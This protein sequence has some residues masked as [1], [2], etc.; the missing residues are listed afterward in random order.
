MDEQGE[1]D[2]LIEREDVSG[3]ADLDAIPEVADAVLV[4]APEHGEE[5]EA[6]KIRRSSRVPG[7]DAI[8]G[9]RWVRI[10]LSRHK[11]K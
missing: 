11:R 7:V 10:I 4:A 9:N 8:I 6:M 5:L 2:A 1:R 3:E